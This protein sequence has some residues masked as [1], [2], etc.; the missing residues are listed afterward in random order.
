[1]AK[2]QKGMPR[3]PNAGRKKGTPNKANTELQSRIKK[4]IEEKYGVVDYDPV[5]AMA[6]IAHEKK[7]PIEIRQKC[8]SEVAQYFHPKKRA[9]EVTG[10]DGGPVEMRTELVDGIVGLLKK[11]K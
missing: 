10:A 9:I 7:H 3:P 8:H 4:H 1:M 11:T 5:L 2:F 6:E